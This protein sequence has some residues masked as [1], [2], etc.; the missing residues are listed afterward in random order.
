MIKT[1]QKVCE[2]QGV[3]RMMFYHLRNKKAGGKGC[4]TTNLALALEAAK[5]YGGKPIDYVN[6]RMRSIALQLHPELSKE[7]EDVKLKDPQ[8]PAESAKNQV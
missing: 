4:K 7:I 1:I 2:E 6:D 5:R 3:S 8:G